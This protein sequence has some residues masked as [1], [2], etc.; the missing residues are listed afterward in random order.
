[1]RALR[2][3]LPVLTVGIL[4]L[5]PVAVQAADANFFGP[6]INK[7]CECPGSAPDWGCVLQTVQNVI[8]LGISLGVI[9]F[10]LVFAYAGV[11]LM[12]S[13]TNP[14]NKKKAKNMLLTTVIGFLV[15]LSAWLLV[16][17]VMKAVYNEG[18]FGPWN[19]ILDENSKRTCILEQTPPA[20][21]TPPPDTS[22]EGGFS[23]GDEVECNRGG[24]GTYY[25]GTINGI[26]EDEDGSNPRV[27][28]SYDDGE[29]E[30]LIPA[31]RCRLVEEE[32]GDITG[33][34][35]DRCPGESCSSLSSFGVACDA[36]GCQVANLLGE[37]LA[38]IEVGFAVTEAY[39]PSRTHCAVCHQRGRCIDAGLRPRDYTASNIQAFLQAASAEGLDADFET[40][41]GDPNIAQW[42]AAGITVNT[43]PGAGIS[44]RHFSV[45]G[46]WGPEGSTGGPGCRQN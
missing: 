15:V 28:V 25:P 4:M 27:S 22:I 7:E 3:L 17:F 21:P 6:I 5:A 35:N 37:K 13:A 23:V 16:D 29:S 20:G 38:Q 12:A 34:T 46:P 11:L 40:T 9:F 1:M 10:V 26:S 42:R 31:S 18:S 43:F 32:G 45:Y 19:S 8:N 14:E 44:G 24:L 2:L 39:P 33:S 30:S 36:G 41:E